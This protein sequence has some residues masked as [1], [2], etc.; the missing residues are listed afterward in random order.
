MAELEK[1][2]FSIKLENSFLGILR[3]VILIVLA[4]SLIGTAVFAYIG[5]SSMTATPQKYEYKAPDIKEMVQEIKKSLQEKP[6]APTDFE[7]KSEEPK[8]SDRLDKEI[9]R[10]VKLISVFLQRYNRSLTDS[11]SFRNGL[12]NQALQLPFEPESEASVMK[13]AEGQTEFF[14]MVF[15]D[16]DILAIVDKQSEYKIVRF[17]ETATQA[18]PQHF[19]NE[20]QTA[21]DF[22]KEQQSEVLTKKATAAV[23]LYVAAGM[24][25]AF[26]VISLI[27]VLVK[28]ERNLRV[29]PI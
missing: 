24:F 15:T 27:L 6:A 8:K 20:H 26:L 23:S 1:Q 12:K 4:V 21:D 13:Y 3:I 17:F 7:T 5:V 22:A 10:Q 18:Y 2:T 9:D 14:E 11:A 16:K 25:G 29:K 19:S 28:I